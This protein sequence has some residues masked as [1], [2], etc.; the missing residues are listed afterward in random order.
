[1]FFYLDWNHKRPNIISLT[2]EKPKSYNFMEKFNIDKKSYFICGNIDKDL[3]NYYPPHKKEYTKPQY[4]S[5]HLQKSI[6]RMND[7][8]SVKTA[9][10]FLDLD[11]Q[12]FLRRLPIIM[13]EDVCLHESLSVIVWLMIAITKGFQIKEVIVK[14]L[15]G[16]VYYLSLEKTKQEY[17]KDDHI[18]EINDQNIS[19]K[20]LLYSLLFRKAYGGMAGDI[21]MIN[22]Y[23]NRVIK[24]EII[25]KNDKIPRILLT[26][27]PLKRSEWLYQANDFHCNRYILNRI[28]L[29]HDNFSI[30]KIKELIWIYSSSI[31]LR[32]DFNRI[33][34][35]EWIKIKKT[36]KKLQKLCNFK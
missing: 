17:Q 36:V 15:L 34:S 22:N 3:L 24:S 27:E 35:S 14:W 23:I 21:R 9:K 10:H 20:T 16:V 6:R 12:S 28:K 30:D 4:L 31:N 19:D 7:Y 13:L 1:M 8:L 32:E 25:I 11:I 26:L 29:K 18:H 33:E 5:S 2:N